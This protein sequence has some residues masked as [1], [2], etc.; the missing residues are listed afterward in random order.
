MWR[1]VTSAHSQFLDVRPFSLSLLAIRRIVPPEQTDS[2][3]FAFSKPN[4]MLVVRSSV[5]KDYYFEA[6][7]YEERDRTIHL[8]KMVT[9][10]LVSYAVTQNSE[11]MM[12]EFFNEYTGFGD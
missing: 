5:G 12:N 6:S 10:R 9:A 4:C 3:P 1:E 7:S 8:W 11:G 2:C